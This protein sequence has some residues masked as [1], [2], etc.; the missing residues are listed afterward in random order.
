[1][2]NE[3][4]KREEELEEVFARQLELLKAESG[5]WLKVG[6]IALAVGL[7]AFA[8]IKSRQ[9]KKKDVTA[10][11]MAVLEREGLLNKDIERKLNQKSKSGFWPSLSER[12]LIMGLAFAKDKFLSNLFAAP[13]EDVQVEEESKKHN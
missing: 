12:L 2:K 7:I 3:L 13:A 8:L 1:M 4:K 9:N 6:G 11:A 10:A 5:D